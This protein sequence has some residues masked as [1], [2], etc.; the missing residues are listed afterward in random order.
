MLIEN[1]SDIKKKLWEDGFF[2]FKNFFEKKYI[3]KIKQKINYVFLNFCKKDNYND[4]IVFDLFKNDFDSFHGC[5]NVCQN[6]PEIFRLQSDELLI[7]YLQ[8][9]GLKQPII[10]TRPLIS[11]SSKKTAKNDNYWKVP[12][13]QDWPST[14]GSINGLTCWIPLV[15]T[16]KKLG[17]LEVI[18]KSHLLG[19][20]DHDE[21]TGVPLLKYSLCDD[22]QSIEMQVGDVLF[23]NYF[24]I[25]RSGTNSTDNKIRWSLH[26]RYDDAAEESFVRRKFPRNRID[27]R[28][29]NLNDFYS[30]SIEEINNF[31]KKK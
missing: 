26:L 7:E 1:N 22:W 20:L 15:D 23:F 25:H 2:L 21:E 12:A 17:C 27:V 11:I 16:D 3:E 10:N 9:L 19:C 31:I 13:H 18:P 29:K 5:A 6:L 4:Q 30:P 28:R 14:Q 24:T 8:T